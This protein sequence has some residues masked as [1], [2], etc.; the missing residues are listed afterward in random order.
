M[1]KK[2][3]PA[4]KSPKKQGGSKE[5]LSKILTAENLA[6]Y[7]EAEPY[8]LWDKEQKVIKVFAEK[9]ATAEERDA[10]KFYQDNLQ[11]IEDNV[12]LV[13]GGYR[14][15]MYLWGRHGT[16]KSWT[17]KHTMLKHDPDTVYLTGHCDPDGF[18]AALQAN[19][20]GHICLDDTSS[21]F[22][23]KTGKQLAAAALGKQGDDTNERKVKRKGNIACFSGGVVI[24]SNLNPKTDPV[25]KAV[26]DRCAC[27]RFQPSKEKVSAFIRYLAKKGKPDCPPARCVEVA[28]WYLEMCRKY[29]VEPSVRGALDNSVGTYKGW[30]DKK[31]KTHW[32]DMIEA[33]VSEQ[34]D[35]GHGFAEQ[36]VL[37]RAEQTDKELEIA[38]K[39]YQSFPASMP[40]FRARR[41]AEWKKRTATEE[42]PEGLSSQA[43]YRKFKMLEK[44]GL[45]KKK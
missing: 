32:K 5:D 45:I 31:I 33:Q 43:M 26:I 24:I 19:P 17:V 25:M 2:K 22:S 16:G 18:F 23:T 37:G 41:L 6:R 11:K 29:D 7:R 15:G 39:I 20:A 35:K 28:E 21:L 42:K 36:E 27:I 3:S 13:M 40:D 8:D 4:K 10:L 14:T 34:S 30:V 44:E 9:A 38:L 1:A 12:A